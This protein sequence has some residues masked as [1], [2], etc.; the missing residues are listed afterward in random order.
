MSTKNDPGTG[1]NL[2]RDKEGCEQH[3]GTRG[4]VFQANRRVV[5]EQRIEEQQTGQNPVNHLNPRFE[6]HRRLRTDRPADAGIRRTDMA[7]ERSG[8]NDD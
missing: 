5:N 4:P 1:C 2:T 7:D 8:V 3:T 6:R